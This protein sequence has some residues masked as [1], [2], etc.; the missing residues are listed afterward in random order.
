PLECLFD[1]LPAQALWVV[2]E[3]SQVAAEEER[4]WEELHEERV[5]A[6]E[7]GLLSFEVERLWMSPDA[8]RERRRQ[9]AAL[10]LDPLP[11]DGGG[12][13]TFAAEALSPFRG[14]VRTFAEELGRW[15]EEGAS[16]L[17]V[18][19]HRTQ[20]NRVEGLL[21]DHDLGASLHP[22]DRA[23]DPSAFRL[24]IAEGE[25]SGSFRLPGEGLVGDPSAQARW[26]PLVVLRERDIFFAEVG[27][28]RRPPPR[29]VPDVFRDLRVGGL[30]VH[31]DYGVGR[32]VGVKP[33]EWEGGEDEFLTVDYAG[34]DRLY[35]PMDNLHL[36]Q[37]YVGAGEG[38][39]RLDRMGGAAWER[40]KRRVK[41]SVRTI[42]R[43]LIEL[44][45]R[46]QLTPGHA[47]APDGGWE[48]EFEEAFEFEETPHQAQAIREVIADME[49]PR[50]MDRL[51]CGDVGYGKTEV[52][53]RASFRTVMGGRQVAVVV[54]TTL[55]AH[56]HWHTF[57]RRFAPYPVRVEML[58]RFLSRK[59]Q[60]AVLE[61]LERGTVDIAIGTH[62]LLQRD[63]RF[64]DLGLFV[65][66]EEHRFGVAHKEKLKRLRTEVDVLTL[67]ATPIPR[68][69]QLSFL[70]IRD[71]SVIETPPADRLAIRT[72][73]ARFNERTIREAIQRELERGGQVFFVHNRVRSLPALARYVGRLVPHARV[74]V[75]HGQM[76][77]RELEGVMERFV[78]GE[79][80]VLLCTTIVESGL[81][82]P[83]V[84]T[85]LVSRADALG[86]AQLYQLRGRVGRDRLQAH[87][88]LLVPSA[89]GL[90]EEAR[91]RLQALEEFSELGAG[92]RL[93]ARDLEIRGAGNILG[94]RQ[95]GHIAAVGLGLYCQLMEEAVA[96]LRGERPADRAETQVKLPPV[97]SLPR[98]Y[99]P[100]TN[101]RLDVYRRAAA[102]RSA[103]EA[104]ELAREVEDRYGRAPEP[105]RRLFQAAEV[106]AMARAV[107]L[108]RLEV[109]GQGAVFEAAEGE[110]AVTPAFLEIP[111]MTFRD[112]HT[113]EVPLSGRWPEDCATLA[114]T[115]REFASCTRRGA[116]EREADS[117]EAT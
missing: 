35:V 77:E 113:F 95:S 80:D 100:D 58:S 41:E 22:A 54:P 112:G 67:T 16:V 30:V 114:Y 91:Q 51:V 117:G 61:G 27:V 104:E 10:R 6:P 37:R 3:P 92:F 69:L 28:G 15:L 50:P 49:R 98:G 8:C 68:T 38:S 108:K 74:A 31:T 46:R 60:V 2:V 97:G 56:Q 57:R 99:I 9:F 96:E 81:D 115:L 84:N 34:G 90:T 33:L 101:Q 19:A 21:K 47:F 88:Y 111:G 36:V 45:A 66:D 39:P 12:L 109:Q 29:R 59:E 72:Y 103:Q 11:L 63:V 64:A 83:A 40:A 17:L 89:S 25:A 85:L 43:E 53:M 93:A 18:V 52:A 42:A 14:R 32:F 71:L 107:G 110:Y 102:A 82:I 26:G 73:I 79:V 76:P 13:P 86:L 48:R 106:R 87:A 105:V 24:A 20:A 1:H 7:R 75:A 70:G 65:V 23:V 5:R 55:L 78:R 116:P 62:R 94:H 44:Y 4:L